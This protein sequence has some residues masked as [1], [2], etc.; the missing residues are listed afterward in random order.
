MQGQNN[1]HCTPAQLYNYSV[2]GRVKVDIV[3]GQIRL[4]LCKFVYCKQEDWN[5]TLH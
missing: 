4:P 3:R 5:Y 2:W 1:I